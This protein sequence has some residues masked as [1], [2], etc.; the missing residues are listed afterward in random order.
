[1]SSDKSNSDTDK[2]YKDA[3]KIIVK[4]GMMPFPITDTLI[5]ILKFYL[6]DEDLEF[7]KAFKFKQSMTMDQLKSKLKNLSEEEIDRRAKKLAKKGFMFNQPS[8]KGFMV[9]RLMPI[10]M[11]GAF[12]YQ[13]MQKLPDDEKERE[14]IRKIAELY[15]K[16]MK[17][18]AAKIQ[19]GY[20]TIVP[21]FASQPPVDRTVPLYKTEDGTT[22][23]INKSMEVGEQILPAQTVE[24]IINKFDDIAV[25][26]CF[27]RQYRKM[28]GQ[29]CKIDAPM[30]VCFTFGK[31]ARHVIEQGFGRR[32]TKEEAIKIMKQA[33]EAGLVHKA[34]HNASDIYRDENSICNCCK[35][36]CDTFNL[37]RMGAIPIINSTNYLSQVNQEICIGCGTC[38]E[39][40]PMDAISL[41]DDDKAQ[42]NSDRCIGCGV[43]AHFCPEHAITLLEG[44]RKV[45]I[46]PPKIKS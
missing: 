11:I 17:E 9:Y 8:S 28:L 26:N 45:F 36:C 6:D 30:E 44:L 27:C 42:V 4:A 2:K 35:C 12:E 37:W 15:E 14:R 40:C 13:F 34:F 5:E 10:V 25:G 18:F 16:Y 23:E 32:V 7:I 29:P 31:S 46:P 24:E 22:I 33:E 41:N 20:D 43:C 3:A 19:E 39:R 1:M 21:A 38:V